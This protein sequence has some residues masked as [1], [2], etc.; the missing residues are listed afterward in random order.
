M[1]TEIRPLSSRQLAWTVAGIFM[2][3]GFV[4]LALAPT[5]AAHATRMVQV[6]YAWFC[7]S[8]IFVAIHVVKAADDV[9]HPD[10][11]D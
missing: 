10:R 5:V 6:A 7:V 3:I 2:S 8:L 4:G 9:R 1:S 11:N